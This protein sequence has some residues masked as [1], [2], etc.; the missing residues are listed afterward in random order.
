MDK[1]EFFRVLDNLY[2]AVYLLDASRKITHWNDGA[3][4]LTGY[5]ADEMLGADCHEKGFVHLG[6]DGE[7]LCDSICPLLDTDTLHD[8]RECQVYLRHKEG[9]LV[10]AR[11]RMV[12]LRDAEGHITGAAEIFSDHS[13]GEEIE[14]RLK[15]LEQLAR[16]DVLT[17]LPNRK[18]LEEQV[19][20]HLA[21]LERFDRSSG[22]LMIDLDGFE[23]LN[24]TFGRESGD[25]ILR[26]IARTWFL[27][28]RPFDTVGRWDEDTFAVI[29]VQTDQEGLRS[30]AERF[31]M[32]LSNLQ[33]PWDRGS[34][35]VGA[36]IGGTM[37]QRGDDTQAVLLRAEK[38]M[39]D[40]KLAGGGAVE[41]S[42]QH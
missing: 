3:E 24:K 38:R 6:K 9:H 15:E 1:I 19:T 36:S 14:K 5:T 23:K 18:H 28:A 17:R 41:I 21:E 40:A 8:I 2:D 31:L 42:D 7:D 37:L 26:M 12:P 25:E 22:I 10:P 20:A 30:V 34:L 16:L 29:A 32:L 33:R 27:S 4:K 13:V 11:A 39:E 35:G